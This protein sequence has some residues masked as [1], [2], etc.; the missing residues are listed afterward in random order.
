MV[1]PCTYD[2]Q[3]EM[4]VGAFLQHQRERLLEGIE[5]ARRDMLLNQVAANE[6]DHITAHELED[7][8]APL[9]EAVDGIMVSMSR[10]YRSQLAF[11]EAATAPD[12]RLGAG[13]NERLA[14]V[15]KANRIRLQGEFD[16][17]V[18]QFL[19][20]CSWAGRPEGKDDLP[21]PMFVG[22]L[23]RR[24]EC[25]VC[26]AEAQGY[27]M[28]AAACMRRQ[29]AQDRESMGMAMKLSDVVGAIRPASGKAVED[30]FA[31]AEA[32]WDAWVA[33]MVRA[34]ALPKPEGTGD[35]M[36]EAEL[37]IQLLLGHERY[38]AEL[39]LPPR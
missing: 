21:L 9:H 29:L 12:E 17:A 4:P 39:A 20:R 32:A 38:L 34:R 15:R 35:P 7:W 28:E 25:C 26:N 13:A 33:A 10:A 3:Q 14:R 18:S 11:V 27:A 36:S 31:E 5:A 19:A 1:I 16:R 2:V 37:E 8:L 22:A 23:L 30:V 6:G 24:N